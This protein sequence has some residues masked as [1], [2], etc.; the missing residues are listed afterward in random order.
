MALKEHLYKSCVKQGDKLLFLFLREMR[1][2]GMNIK[3]V[4]KFGCPI[5]EA[6]GLIFQCVVL[7]NCLKHSFQV[8]V[9]S[10]QT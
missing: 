6:K 10:T 3:R 9:G 4:H 1:H 8:A 5:C 7:C 2:R